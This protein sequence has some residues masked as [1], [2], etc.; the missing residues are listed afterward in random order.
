V[1]LAAGH[2]KCVSAGLDGLAEARSRCL[3]LG[4]SCICDCLSVYLSVYVSAL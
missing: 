3:G 2:I 4:I 1:F